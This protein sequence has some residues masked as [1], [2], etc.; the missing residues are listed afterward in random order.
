[1]H[2]RSSQFDIFHTCF[3]P[4]SLIEIPIVFNTK[5]T[6]TKNIHSVQV[7]AGV[8]VFVFWIFSADY[9]YS[10]L[11]SDMM[12]VSRTWIRNCR[13]PKTYIHIF[14]I[15]FIGFFPKTLHRSNEVSVCIKGASDD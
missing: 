10:D 6:S 12:E 2:S 7:T 1:M 9:L 4:Y 8:I 15:I 5:Y 11:E 14:R 3:C 13:P